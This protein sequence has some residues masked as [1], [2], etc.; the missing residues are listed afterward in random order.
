MLLLAVLLTG[1]LGVAARY[2][3]PGDAWDTGRLACP[4]LVSDSH[5]GVAHRT[6]PC[7]TR[8]RICS[9]SACAD[10]VVIDRGP[11]GAQTAQG[12]RLRRRLH[13]G[14]RY[15]GELDLRAPLAQRL[16]VKGKELVWYR[17]LSP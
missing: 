15:V 11:Y 2:A 1:Q 6:A 3:D 7:G 8:L 5:H 16:G 14:E 10:A 4:Q 13:H 9:S 12:W 17:W